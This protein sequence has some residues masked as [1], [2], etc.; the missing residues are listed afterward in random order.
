METSPRIILAANV[1]DNGGSYP[2]A[3]WRSVDEGR[4]FGGERLTKNENRRL[5]ARG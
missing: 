2:A 1:A 3:L 5:A 4:R